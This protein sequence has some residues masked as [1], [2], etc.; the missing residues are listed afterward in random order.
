MDTLINQ[1]PFKVAFITYKPKKD[2]EIKSINYV[3]KFS[4]SKDI[5]FI[6]DLNLLEYDNLVVKLLSKDT[7]DPESRLY[8][9]CFEYID[10]IKDS[11]D[12]DENGEE[13]VT[14]N[15]EAIIHR[16]YNNDVSFPLIPGIY[17]IKVLWQQTY[18]YSQ[19]IVKPNNLE[20]EEHNQMIY[21]IE[22]HA[23]GLA[24]DWIRKNSSL[25]FLNGMD[26]MDPT[27]L[28]YASILVKNK[29]LLNKSIIVI[30]NNPNTSL[31]KEY[32]LMPFIKSK[33]ID[34]KSLRMSQVKSNAS[35]YNFRS[36]ANL[37]IYS[38]VMIDVYDNNVNFYLIN[39]IKDFQTILK[40][41]KLDIVAVLNYLREDLHQ[42]NRYKKEYNV[43]SMLKITNREKQ[44][45][46]VEKFN[47]SIE[48]LYNNLSGFLN[49]TFLSE[50]IVPYKVNLSQQFIK[51]PGYNNFYKIHK[52]IN[53]NLDNDIEDL[54]EYNWKSSEVL[55]EYWCFIKLVEI[56]IEL[57]FTPTD[58]WIYSLE[59]DKKG[60]S[61]P[62]IPDNTFVTFEK[63]QTT[64]KLLF[65]SAI[66]QLPKQAKK[67]ESS[68]WTRSNR[69]KP[70]FRIDIY[71]H[72][73]F[74]KTI[75][76]DSKYSPANRVWNK[77]LNNSSNSSKVVEQL[78]M[79]VNM[80]IKINTRNTHVVEE[81]IA[82]CP[83]EINNKQ[84]IEHDSNHLVT[85]ATMKPGLENNDLKE[86]LLYLITEDV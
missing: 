57:K 33:K 48:D 24:R 55:Y 41:A 85:I 40:K 12:F 18:Y 42:L 52:L 83:T 51:T 6:E 5:N 43:G 84:L 44:I 1:L 23:K 21:E 53:T 70:D 77:R 68:Y 7:V 19:I 13:F 69:N 46:K 3:K 72:G 31:F 49:R 22:M 32:Q 15:K 67:N 78:K 75:I 86:R 79:Y 14:L 28:D 80:I 58:G 61:I 29:S 20:I 25:D 50:L 82:L 30:L 27:Y 81:V 39:V 76:L 56:L 16:H 26:K 38:H 2:K 47:S 37:E 11:I 54:Y 62:A 65:N 73:Q 10:E 35:L 36:S 66:E 60:I 45:L 64:I 59:I 17:R 8:M 34:G 71:E 74:I 9:D 63:N 4:L